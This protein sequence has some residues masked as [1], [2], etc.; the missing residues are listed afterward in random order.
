MEMVA[1][2]AL[3]EKMTLLGGATGL[4]S[5]L[6]SQQKSEFDSLV[7]YDCKRIA[8]AL[9]SSAVRKCVNAKFGLGTK[10]LCRFDFVESKE[11]DPEQYLALAKQCQDLGIKVDI[12]K[13]RELTGLQ[14]ISEEEKD[15]WSPKGEND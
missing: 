14:F 12:A 13:L 15:V 4:G 2:L 9:T 1:L 7:T 10:L 6:A 5:D 3:G 8:N 11:V